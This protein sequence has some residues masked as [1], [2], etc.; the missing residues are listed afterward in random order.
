[1]VRVLIGSVC[2]IV[3]LACA[4]V[5]MMPPGEPEVVTAVG[6]AP[7]IDTLE[8]YCSFASVVCYFREGPDEEVRFEVA[9]TGQYDLSVGHTETHGMLA[10]DS[11]HAI[12]VAMHRA[13]YES[14]R[15]CIQEI[16]TG[17]ETLATF[18]RAVKI[19]GCDDADPGTDAARVILR[20]TISALRSDAHI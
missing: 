16:W 9:V 13:R 2:A 10:D 15:S 3:V 19:H 18:N 11:L 5:V 6:S 7:E 4:L 20:D 14:S 17:D 12:V 8:R 1:M